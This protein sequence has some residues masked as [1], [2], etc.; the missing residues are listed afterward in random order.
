[1]DLD[2]ENLVYTGITEA[3]GDGVS[4]GQTAINDDVKFP[5]VNVQMDDFYEVRETADS[6]GEM[7]YARV[8]FSV[9]VYSITS[10]SETKKIMNKVRE[11]MR[12]IGFMVTSEAPMQE[13][14]RNEIYRR[15]ATFE[16]TVSEDK[17]FL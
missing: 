6:S 13:G 12:S 16:A 8:R 10:K 5:Y 15:V 3:V 7:K 1:M 11:Y 2:H 9:N 4:C 14:A 17:V